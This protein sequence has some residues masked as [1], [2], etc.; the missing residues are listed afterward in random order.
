MNDAVEW[1]RRGEGPQ[2]QMHLGSMAH[3]L[4]EQAKEGHI[5]SDGGP[6]RFCKT[7]SGR[8]AL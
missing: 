5:M 7:C 1:W 2:W 8:H 3:R 4:G 6:A